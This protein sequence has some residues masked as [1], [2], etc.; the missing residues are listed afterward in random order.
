MKIALLSVSNRTTL[1]PYSYGYGGMTRVNWWL[2]EELVRIGHDVIMF[3]TKDSL[4][5]VGCGLVTYPPE[6]AKH[7]QRPPDQKEEVDRALAE[8]FGNKW[9]SEFDV[10]HE[11][12]H[13]HPVALFCD[14]PILATMQNPNTRN[15]WGAFTRNLV[16]VSPAHADKYGEVPFVFNAVKQGE[17]IY[18]EEKDGPFLLMGA[19]KPYKGIKPTIEAAIMA[20]VELDLAG[21][22]WN[23]RHGQEC[24][25]LIKGHPKIRWL[26]EVQGAEKNHLVASAKAAMLYVQWLEPGTMFGVEAMAAGTPIIG[27]GKGCIP[28]YV[29]DGLTG[30]ICENVSD[31]VGSMME[32]DQIDPEMCYLR[33]LAHFTVQTQAQEYLSL[34]HR[35]IGGETW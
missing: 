35:T 22:Q 30:Y 14:G 23:G 1:P 12:S 11:M 10:I 25:E 17:Q 24:Q 31:M 29:M 5:P 4:Q 6:V 9:L 7:N 34:Y 19:M 15:R 33:Y 27:S 16:A 28:D 8:W 20:D 2:A 32:I 18:C 21:T 13:R 3:A 26:G